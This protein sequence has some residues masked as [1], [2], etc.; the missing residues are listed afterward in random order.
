[1]HICASLVTIC[2]LMTLGVSCSK[3][4][5][6]N[7]NSKTPKSLTDKTQISAPTP[8]STPD[9]KPKMASDTPNEDQRRIEEVVQKNK[10]LLE[11]D[12][13]N[14]LVGMSQQELEALLGLPTKIDDRNMIYRLDS[15]LGG[16]EW[17]FETH[18][19]VVTRVTIRHLN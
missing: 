11:L 8:N 6:R 13:S 7:A 16:V 4:D 2:L 3:K 15:G 1:M 14:R 12:K 9:E 10:H 18:N 17:N 5:S 19:H